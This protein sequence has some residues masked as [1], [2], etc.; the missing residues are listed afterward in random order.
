MNVKFCSHWFSPYS[1]KNSM[2][3]MCNVHYLQQLRTEG[4]RCLCA[5]GF[6][7]H[8]T[9]RNILNLILDSLI[10]SG[11]RSIIIPDFCGEKSKFSPGCLATINYF[12][13]YVIW[14]QNSTVLWLG[15]GIISV[16]Y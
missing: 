5:L 15:E 10:H 3:M 14:L 12:M 8:N 1:E 16:S 4:S 7:L 6:T 13:I 9:G 2:V 11:T